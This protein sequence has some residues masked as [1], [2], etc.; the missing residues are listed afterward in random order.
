MAPLKVE[1]RTEEGENVF[2]CSLNIFEI[3]KN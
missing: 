3:A 2:F 1:A